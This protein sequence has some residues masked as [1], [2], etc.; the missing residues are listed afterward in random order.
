MVWLW[1]RRHQADHAETLAIHR[2]DE[3]RRTHD[4]LAGRII[5]TDR[6]D[7]ANGRSNT[8]LGSAAEG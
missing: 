2:Y 8:S 5:D 6:R 1:W 4:R 3:W 7:D